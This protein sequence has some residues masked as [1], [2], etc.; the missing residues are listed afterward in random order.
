MPKLN[1][2][3]STQVPEGYQAPRLASIE[4]AGATEREA[5]RGIYN[6]G[7][8]VAGGL[9]QVYNQQTEL[10]RRQQEAKDQI[11]A[12]QATTAFERDF[13][14]SDIKLRQADDFDYTTHDQKLEQAGRQLMSQYAAKLSPGAAQKFGISSE[15]YLSEK[16]INTKYEAN[17]RLAADY[18]TTNFQ[19]NE[20]VVNDLAN[21]P[22]PQLRQLKA[23]EQMRE[24]LKTEN[25]GFITAKER[26][27]RDTRLKIGPEIVLGNRAI[28]S[29]PD[30]F[31]VDVRDPKYLPNIR[32]DQRTK[33]EE[34]AVKVAAAMDV[35]ADKQRKQTSAELRKYFRDET[36]RGVDVDSQ[37]RENRGLMTTDDYEQSLNWNAKKLTDKRT[38]DDPAAV[39]RIGDYYNQRRGRDWGV[40]NQNASGLTTAT[41]RATENH[42]RSLIDEDRKEGKSDAEQ[43][44]AERIKAGEVLINTQFQSANIMNYD[45]AMDN[46]RGAALSQYHDRL[47][48]ENKPGQKVVT[49]PVILAH[50]M[51]KQH[52][53]AVLD[54]LNKDTGA[55]EKV[56]WFRT[57]DELNA[58]YKARQ[59]TSNPMSGGDYWNQ[60]FM[61]DQ[62][63]Y[64]SNYNQ[65]VAPPPVSS[66]PSKGSGTPNAGKP[67]PGS[68]SVGH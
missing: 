28:D 59:N 14:Q 29:N 46:A 68:M 49:D 15:R 66:K 23:D 31:L 53:P 60:K 21:T 12:I 58:A 39:K 25:R 13:A 55:M 64:F 38:E 37:I 63:N 11:A 57:I 17:K 16:V 22:D 26:M 42:I 27:D 56:L 6:T 67:F 9:M 36:D 34:R 52:I 47:S 8:Q 61:I 44:R 65:S 54:K 32:E 4:E 20:A 7:Q 50:E 51:I 24:N 62:Y 41:Y 33:L 43:T 2:Y 19:Q 3:T 18:N 5:A 45:K 1:L 30:K 10:E 40:F 48:T 35:Q